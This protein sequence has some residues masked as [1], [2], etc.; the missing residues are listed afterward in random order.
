MAALKEAIREYEANKW[1]TIGQKVNKP[2]KVILPPLWQD[3]ADAKRHASNLPKTIS[4]ECDECDVD[5]RL[6]AYVYHSFD[7]S[8]SIWAGT[9]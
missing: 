2:P 5:D 1:K 8:H 4:A 3:Y 7:S 9:S 6:K